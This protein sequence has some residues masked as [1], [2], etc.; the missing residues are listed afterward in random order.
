MRPGE[1]H[2]GR[3]GGTMIADLLNALGSGSM[4]LLIALL[5]AGA[6]VLSCLC[7]S[8]T[9]VVLLATV[10][11]M[12]TKGEDG[13][14]GW[15]SIIVFT[16]LCIGVE[17]IEQ[18]ASSWG[19]VRRGGSRLAGFMAFAGGIAGMLIGTAIIPVV[20]SL[21]GMLVGS[22]GCVF[23]VEAHR[24]KQHQQA[25]SIAWGAVVA[26]LLVGVL[27]VTLTMGMSI[28]LLVGVALG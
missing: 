22:F 27:K 8:G 17:V 28:W 20:G 9:W 18:V 25:A 11:A 23:L 7:F 5:C 14:P 16:I 13:F 6:L 15:G 3:M 19:V 26:R 1:G 2:P 12:L 21:V 4:A 24:L 10:L